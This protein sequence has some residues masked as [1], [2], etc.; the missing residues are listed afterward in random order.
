MLETL[1]N[2]WKIEDLRKKMLYTLFILALTRIG[3]QI[4]VPFLNPLALGAMEIGR[5]H[6]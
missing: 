3:S 2:A 5:A 4:P 6:V 1:R